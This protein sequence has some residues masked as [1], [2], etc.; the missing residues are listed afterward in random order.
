MTRIVRGAIEAEVAHQSGALT[1]LPDLPGNDAGST[2]A[3][4]RS[5]LSGASALPPPIALQV[6]QIADL[7]RVQATWT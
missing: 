1:N 4:I 2:A 5:V 7:A 6:R 3:Y